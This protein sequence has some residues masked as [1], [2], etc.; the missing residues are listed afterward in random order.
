MIAQNG[1]G[2]DAG[3]FTF[4]VNREDYHYAIDILDQI[5]PSLHAKQIV[6]DTK[7]AKLSIVGV[8][9]GS[10]SGVASTMLH[11]LGKEGIKVQN[12]STSEIKVSV[13]IDEKYLELGMRTLHAAFGLAVET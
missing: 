2:K 4:T 10:H 8:G 13:I 5:I 6:G 7:V 1:N 3:D 11:A 9:I 12:I